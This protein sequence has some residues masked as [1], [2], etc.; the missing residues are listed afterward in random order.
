[1]KPK[2]VFKQE[3]VARAASNIHKCNPTSALA[4]RNVAEITTAL[5]E[6]LRR[7]LDAGEIVDLRGVGRFSVRS[8]K[9]RPGRHPRTGAVIELAARK[10]VHYRPAEDLNR[11]VNRVKLSMETVVRAQHNAR[12]RFLDALGGVGAD[13]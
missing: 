12:P 7:A 6:E 9:A 1:M 5:V 8:K 11:R 2:V 3:L 10:V 13:E 4:K